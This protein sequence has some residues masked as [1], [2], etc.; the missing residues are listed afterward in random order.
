MKTKQKRHRWSSKKIKLLMRLYP[1]TPNVIIAE[2]L[3]LPVSCVV[4]KA[5]QLKLRKSKEYL[6]KLWHKCAEHPDM[7]AT[8]FKPGHVPSNKGK[9]QKEFMSADGIEKTKATRFKT[10]HKPHNIKPVGYE[11]VHADG[12]TYVK[13]ENGMEA[14]HRIIWK[15][16]FGEIPNGM[17]VFFLDGN[18]QNLSIDNLALEDMA[19]VLSRTRNK[20]TKQQREAMYKKA[21]QTRNK[22]IE[23]DKRRIRWGLPP[24]TKLVKRYHPLKT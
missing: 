15:Q 22:N 14:K 6:A 10:G 23:K 19:Q 16:H 18:R 20:M 4:N 24:R 13:T 1:E 11:T 3:K 17:R 8:R 9:R 5:F 21:H 2:Q 12:Y 7:I